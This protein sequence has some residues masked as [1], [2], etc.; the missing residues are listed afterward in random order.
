MG[1]VNG[2]LKSN[3]V[4]PLALSMQTTQC[5]LCQIGPAK[6]EKM[7]KHERESAEAIV[8]FIEPRW[9]EILRVE[10]PVS[11]ATWTK[12]TEII[13]HIDQNLW[14]RYDESAIYDPQC[15]TFLTSFYE[16]CISWR[17][18]VNLI[19]SGNHKIRH[20]SGEVRNAALKYLE[21]H[22]AELDQAMCASKNSHKNLVDFV[23]MAIE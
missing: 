9:D 21:K 7:N 18:C 23:V 22:I 3:I 16:D 20:L 8:S 14:G 5:M 17:S 19:I 10:A 11:E 4:R 15:W 1:R 2:Y 12:L 13:T 6:E